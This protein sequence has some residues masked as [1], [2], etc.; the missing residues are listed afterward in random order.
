MRF[1]MCLKEDFHLIDGGEADVGLGGMTRT[2]AQRPGRT[3]ETD[4]DKAAK[5]DP[6]GCGRA[7][8]SS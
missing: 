7:H 5:E 8:K 6:A 2:K 1:E 4:G 3:G